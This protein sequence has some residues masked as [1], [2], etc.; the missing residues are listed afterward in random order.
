MGPAT[1]AAV[2]TLGGERNYL[3]FHGSPLNNWHGILR[4][5]LQ[6]FSNTPQMQHGAVHGAGIYLSPEMKVSANYSTQRMK[7]S[8]SLSSNKVIDCGWPNS[9]FGSAPVCVACC[10]VAD[11]FGQVRCGCRASTQARAQV[12]AQ[13]CHSTATALPRPCHGMARGGALQIRC[14]HP[15]E[16]GPGLWRRSTPPTPFNGSFKVPFNS[17]NSTTEHQRGRGHGCCHGHRHQG[18]GG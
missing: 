10:E 9:R 2:G 1:G 6:V 18:R 11:P 4:N 13:H 3:A 15:T 16:I 14:R 5:G 8:S 7:A 12:L 17:S